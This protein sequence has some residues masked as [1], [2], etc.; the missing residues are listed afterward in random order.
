VKR[1]IA[2]DYSSG[3]ALL[4]PFY[5]Y[6]VQQPSFEKIIAERK[7]HAVNRAVLVAHLRQQYAATTASK[8][9]LN[10]IELLGQDTTFTV[11]TGQQPGLFGGPLYVWYKTVS[12]ILLCRKLKAQFPQYDFVP[13]FWVAS[14]DHDFAEVNNTWLGFGNHAAYD[15][16]FTS[17][18]G[19]HVMGGNIGNL[20]GATG[21]NLLRSHY[22]AGNHW[23]QAFIALLNDL[24]GPEGLV[25]LDADALALKQLFI[26][27][28][29][30]E[31]VEGKSFALLAGQ[32]QK[33][34]AMGYKAQLAPREINLFYLTNEAR[35]RLVKTSAGEWGLAEGGKTWAEAQ[36]R[37]EIQAHPERFSPNAALRPVYQES[38]LPNLC[39]VGGWGEIAYWLELLPVFSLYN[40]FYPLVLPRVSALLV[41]QQ[42]QADMAALG[43][44]L[45]D[46]MLPEVALR[47][48]MILRHWNNAALNDAFYDIDIQLS[49]IAQSVAALD[50]GQSRNVLGQQARMRKFYGRLQKKLIRRLAQRHPEWAAPAI[51]LK[52]A[53]QPDGTVQERL[54]NWA[55]FASRNPHALV[56][57]LLAQLDPLD[58]KT[59]TLVV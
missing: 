40:T 11:T 49:L 7:Q 10:N 20:A 25:V 9:V 59:R 54:L 3:N 4:Q 43:L 57:Q 39:Y 17:A 45:L 35:T 34:E 53:I 5:R 32:A 28:L 52:N 18:V 21:A 8:A 30:A 37:D 14:E 41:T 1:S 46:L 26:P 42:Q 22:A 51:G 47:E 56:Q 58:W 38:I 13:V 27:T 15:G 19:R 36:L 29:L 44:G 2:A 55:A 31:A 33:L 16:H 12:C 50:A 24:F 23:G 6:P 48:K